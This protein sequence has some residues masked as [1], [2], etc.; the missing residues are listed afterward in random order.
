MPPAAFYL[1]TNRLV[2]FVA[3][4]SPNHALFFASF[5]LCLI[6]FEFNRPGRIVPGALGLTLLLFATAALLRHPLRPA[7]LVLL[8]L[9]T[10]SLTANLWRQIPLW[11]SAAAT[12]AL[13]LSLRLL[14]PGSENPHIN[15]A[16]ALTCGGAVGLLG[17]FLSRVAL[18]AR[19]LKAVH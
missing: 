19:R 3:S 18:R 9:S 16:S 10:A 11:V 8:L 6:F 1:S 13:A 4:L 14:I 5:G 7:V 15:T 12:V 17:T 2:A